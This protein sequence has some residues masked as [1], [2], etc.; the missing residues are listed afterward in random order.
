MTNETELVNYGIVLY[1]AFQALDV[2]GPLDV[3]NMVSF[4]NRLNLHIIAETMDPVSTKPQVMNNSG[5]DF[6]ESVVPTHTFTEPPEQLDVLIVPGGVGTRS[7]EVTAPVRAY[8][9]EAFPNVKYFLSICTGVGM[10][11]QTGILDGR[12]ATGNK[13]SWAW[14]TAQGPNV[15]WVP[16]ARW[17]EDGNVWTSSGVSAGIDLM[18]A[19]VAKMYGEDLASELA[20][21]MEY[22]RHVNPDW[23]PFAE[24][25]NLTGSSEV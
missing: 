9:L 17:V 1:P 11:A 12:R 25:W 19:F 8:I 16:H 20:L 18:F 6:G 5:S 10:V 14:V 24:Y 22:E 7:D 23:D 3:L 13:R 15:N 2:F 4:S 21:G